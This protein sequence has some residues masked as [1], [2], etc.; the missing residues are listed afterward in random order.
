VLLRTRRVF[1]G[2]HHGVR[3]RIGPGLL[4]KLVNHSFTPLPSSSAIIYL[5]ANLSS[6]AQYVA[7]LQEWQK[8]F[9][10]VLRACKQYSSSNNLRCLRLDPTQDHAVALWVSGYHHP[11]SIR[12]SH[13]PAAF[14]LPYHLPAAHPLALVSLDPTGPY[15]PI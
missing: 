2:K 1:E 12:P 13:R 9:E 6:V 4:S 5:L 8:S 7:F 15:I 11:N 14:C 3:H 10:I